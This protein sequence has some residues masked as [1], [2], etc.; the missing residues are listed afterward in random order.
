MEMRLDQDVHLIRKNLGTSFDLAVVLGSGLGTLTETLDEARSLPYTQIGSLGATRVAGHGGR[1]WSGRLSGWNLL[2]FEGRF[3]LYEG[4]SAGEVVRPVDLAAELGC[5]R[6]LLTNAAG[7]IAND[8][9]PGDF[10]FIADHINLTGDNPLRG[11]TAN[12]FVD[13]SQL[14]RNDLYEPLTQAIADPG[15]RLRSGVLAGLLGPSYETPAEISMLERLGA[16]AVSM[17]TVAEAIKARYHG[18]EIVGLSLI[19]N[20]AAGRSCA[21]LN[22]A[23]VLAEGRKSAVRFCALVRALIQVWV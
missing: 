1:L 5:R 21:S 15:L 13:L 14:Y 7:G 10:M 6:I 20:K 2:V 23:E 18:L 22:H 11:L 3:H 17:S 8:F 9:C 19:S 12:R 4:L 16:H